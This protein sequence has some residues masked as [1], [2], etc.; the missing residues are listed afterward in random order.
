MSEKRDLIRYNILE[1][2]NGSALM[3]TA[4]DKEL[5]NAIRQFMEFQAT[6]HHGN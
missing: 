5:I 4:N 1:M 6:E 2:S 3:L